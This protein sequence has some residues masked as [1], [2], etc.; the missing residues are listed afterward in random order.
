M[1][2]SLSLRYAEPA[3]FAQGS[4]WFGGKLQLENVILEQKAISRIER[5]ERLIS[6]YELLAFSKVLKVSLS[7]LLTGKD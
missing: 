1:K 5:G 7:W 2:Q 4:L 3:P 6:D